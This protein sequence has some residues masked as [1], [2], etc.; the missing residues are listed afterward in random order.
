MGCVVAREVWFRCFRTA[1]IQIDIPDGTKNLETWWLKARK[2]FYGKS[3]RVFDSF[4]MLVCWSLWKHR[5]AYVFNN[6]R[7]HCNTTELVLRILDEFRTWLR[8]RVGVGVGDLVR[9]E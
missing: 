8:V 9:R 2:R 5:N 3:K 1:G 6:T 4:V 7:Q